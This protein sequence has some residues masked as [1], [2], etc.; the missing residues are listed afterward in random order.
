MTSSWQIYGSNSSRDRKHTYV[1]CRITWWSLLRT[2]PSHNYW[3]PFKDLQSWNGLWNFSSYPQWVLSVFPFI[4]PLPSCIR[5]RMDRHWSN[6]TFVQG[7]ECSVLIADYWYHNNR[8][9]STA[10]V[11]LKE[12][13]EYCTKATITKLKWSTQVQTFISIPVGTWLFNFMGPL[14]SCIRVSMVRFWC[15]ASC[16]G[17][18]NVFA[19]FVL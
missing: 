12:T 13:L 11:Y 7:L 18:W 9:G 5:V 6:E 15:L 2:K 8:H 17:Q 16:M 19:V 1:S 10:Y 14:P 4:G 3:S